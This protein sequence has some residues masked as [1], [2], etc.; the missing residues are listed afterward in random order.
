[1]SGPVRAI[2]WAQWRTLL[3][4][5]SGGNL[6]SA[7]LSGLILWG[8]FGLWTLIAAALGLLA[9]QSRFTS[10]FEQGL[11]RALFVA[12]LLWQVVPL[13]MASQGA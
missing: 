3:H 7:A 12:C 8:W 9:A 6:P 2:L 10:M 13:L 1:M 5:R 4:F 11:P